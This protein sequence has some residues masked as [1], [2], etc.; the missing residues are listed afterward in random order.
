MNTTRMNM[1]LLSFLMALLMFF[2]ALPVQGLAESVTGSGDAGQSPAAEDEAEA[3]D[4][5]ATLNALLNIGDDVK[6]VVYHQVT[7]ALPRGEGMDEAEITET[8]T[9][10]E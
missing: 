5:I 6:Q 1:R 3:P 7:L 2:S 8:V 9:E 10:N 4:P